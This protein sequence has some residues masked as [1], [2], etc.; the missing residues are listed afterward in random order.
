MLELTYMTVVG[1]ALHAVSCAVLSLT[2]QRPTRLQCDS[3]RMI[4]L[5]MQH[6]CGVG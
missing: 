1:A 3:S 4:P 6:D 5:L 2:Q